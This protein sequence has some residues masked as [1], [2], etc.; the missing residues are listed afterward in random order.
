MAT[1]AAQCSASNV[2]PKSN[3]LGNFDCSI[4]H[5]AMLWVWGGPGQW[6]T[7]AQNIVSHATCKTKGKGLGL[8]IFVQLL[9]PGP[10]GPTHRLF[11]FAL[12]CFSQVL[13]CSAKQLN[14]FRYCSFQSNKLSHSLHQ[15]ACHK[16]NWA[17]F[18]T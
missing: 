4:S 13:P 5:E 18:C 2:V 6:L 9:G 14:K 8:K 3:L 12:A 16:T 11:I 7:D 1:W 15:W 17:L 10:V